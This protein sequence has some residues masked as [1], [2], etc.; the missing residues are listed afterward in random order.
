MSSL[1]LYKIY[2]LMKIFK[3]ILNFIYK[4]KI[5]LGYGRIGHHG[6]T[7][8]NNLTDLM[9]KNNSYLDPY[10]TYRNKIFWSPQYFL[11]SKHSFEF[12]ERLKYF[13]KLNNWEEKDFIALI[14]LILVEAIRDTTY[15]ITYYYHCKS[16]LTNPFHG[17]I[18]FLIYNNDPEMNYLPMMP[19]VFTKTGFLSYHQTYVENFNDAEIVGCCL[20]IIN[21][22]KT[23]KENYKD[24]PYVRGFITN[25]SEWK[26]FEVHETVVKKTKIIRPFDGKVELVNGFKPTIVNDYKL[27]N[28]IIG[29]I[30]FALNLEDNT[31]LRS[32]SYRLND[33]SEYNLIKNKDTIQQSDDKIPYITEVDLK[34]QVTSR[35]TDLLN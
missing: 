35:R 8:F 10:K 15:D 1:C 32:S 30:R 33:D 31:V 4:T 5:N 6:C 12:K 34:Q 2:N 11:K 28:N 21:E 27:I 25:G 7:H 13:K 26:L 24:F 16:S 18:P 9:I 23:K 20:W 29:L 17:C 22:I 19:I 14:Q 3:N